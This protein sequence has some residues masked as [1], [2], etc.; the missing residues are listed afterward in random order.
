MVLPRCQN[1]SS[2]S[3]SKSG[4]M[5]YVSKTY[6]SDGERLSESGERWL[7]VK[8]RRGEEERR[9]LRRDA[10]WNIPHFTLHSVHTSLFLILFAMS[11]LWSR[12]DF[13]KKGSGGFTLRHRLQ[14]IGS[15]GLSNLCTPLACT[16]SPEELGRAPDPGLVLVGSWRVLGDSGLQASPLP[17]NPLGTCSFPTPFLLLYMASIKGFRHL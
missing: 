5:K 1:R 11:G 7:R 10:L 17:A 15:K 14:P 6:F 3:D 16:P 2:K 8:W 4:E 12:E 9:R 13:L